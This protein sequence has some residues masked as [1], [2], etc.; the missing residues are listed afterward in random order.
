MWMSSPKPHSPYDPPRPYDALYDPRAVPG[1]FGSVDDLADRNP[2]LDATRYAHAIPTLSPQAWQVIRSYYYG[3][4]TFLDAMIGRVVAHLEQ[5]GQLE[6]TLILFSADHGDLLGDFGSCFKANHLNGSVRVP[7]IVAGPGVAQ[8]AVSEALVG[9]QDILPTFASAAGTQVG[10]SIHGHDLSAHLANP[11][12]AQVG[13][14]VFYSSTEVRQM[15][16][17]AMVTDGRWK[18]IYSEA[19][20]TEEL[21]DQV[22]DY[23]ERQNLAASSEHQETL[24]RMR[25]QLRLTATA[26]GDTRI[27]DGDGFTARTVDRSTFAEVPPIAM[28]WRWY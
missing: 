22:H 25:H 17:S 19:N 4:I 2:Y 24:V 8:G 27:L 5:A 10:Q 18:Y 15:G 28:G 7:Y 13:R 16:Q 3:C 26:L 20:A 23:A 6:N 9:L 14:E 1:P 21:Y 12:T 11:R